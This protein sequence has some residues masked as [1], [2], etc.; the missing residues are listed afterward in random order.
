MSDIRTKLLL[1]TTITS[2]SLMLVMAVSLGA[3]QYNQPTAASTLGL[4]GHF[5]II[6]ENPDG[7]VSYAQ[8]DNVVTGAGKNAAGDRLF[9]ANGA[10]FEC[11]ILG[12]GTNSNT[13]ST[14]DAAL[15]NT[16]IDCTPVKLGSDDG[17]NDPTVAQVTSLTATHTISAV[18]CPLSCIL[19]EVA[20][21]DST[22]TA[23]LQ[24][25]GLTFA[26]TAL[27]A[28]VVASNGA[29]VTTIY[30]VATGGAIP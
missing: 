19:T 10:I 27:D 15:V 22:M 14:I 2:V 24:P 4:M 30:L 6:V 16:G 17:T 26:H 11:I 13:A 23:A 1:G 3:V 5:E 28:N 21:G 8:G 20:L 29:T 7:T 9:E 18:D 25:G 12:N